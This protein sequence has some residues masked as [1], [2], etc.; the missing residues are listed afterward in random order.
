MTTTELLALFRTEVSDLEAPYLWSDALI[1]S[2][3]DEAQKQFCRDTYGIADARSY[4]IDLLTDGTEW[5]NIDPGSRNVR[6]S[7]VQATLTI[8]QVRS[9]FASSPEISALIGPV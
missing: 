8:G 2:Y 7:A 5:Y 1:Y 6:S 9:T 3:I 4:T